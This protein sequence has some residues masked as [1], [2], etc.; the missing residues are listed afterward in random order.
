MVSVDGRDYFRKGYS[1]IPPGLPIQYVR[2]VQKCV[3][4]GHCLERADGFSSVPRLPG[5]S[6]LN[7]V[8]KGE[9]CPLRIP[10]GVLRAAVSPIDTW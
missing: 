5:W 2:N 6:F 8:S 1:R 3:W 10:F 9:S 4:G 7:H